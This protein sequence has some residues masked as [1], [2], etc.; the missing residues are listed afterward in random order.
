MKL[1]L[2]LKTLSWKLAFSDPEFSYSVLLLRLVV[3]MFYSCTDLL[4]YFSETSKEGENK[5][6]ALSRCPH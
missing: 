6:E 2:S 4:V 5:D 1:E 3:S